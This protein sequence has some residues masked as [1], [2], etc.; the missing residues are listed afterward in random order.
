M[1]ILILG[2]T[3]RTGTLL[4]A[5]ALAKGHQVTA[6]AR[7]PSKPGLNGIR[8][9][10]GSPM[11]GKLLERTLAGIDAV[12]IA[13]NISRRSDNPFAKVVA[14][15]T[16]ISDTVKALIPA[17]EKNGLKRIITV[18]ASGV[19]DSFNHMPLI[20]RW[21][22]RYSNIWKAYEDHDRQEKILRGSGLD[23]TI[24]RPVMLNNRDSD[25]YKVSMGKP[26]GG[27]ISR[28]GVAKFILDALESGNY[29]K[30]VV[31]LHG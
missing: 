28:K 11:D 29:V 17:M 1:N 26:E 9:L 16:L 13:L 4:A 6:I 21:L 27:N 19:G 3:G 18:S 5:A 31:T 7:D 25:L 10:E 8:T 22:I 14:P 24:A 30:Q 2:A 23:W 20:A 12:V 15:L